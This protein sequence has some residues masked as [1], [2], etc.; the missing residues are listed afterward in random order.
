MRS[1]SVEN[2][3]TKEFEIV[4]FRHLATPSSDDP[5]KRVDNI[6]FLIVGVY[7]CFRVGVYK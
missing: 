6:G 5:K 1:P 2:I 7:A 4:V 3:F